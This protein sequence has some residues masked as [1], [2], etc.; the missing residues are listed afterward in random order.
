[1][2]DDVRL[3]ELMGFFRVKA[4]GHVLGDAVENVL[5]QGRRMRRGRNRMQVDDAKIAF[6]VFQHGRP[7]ATAPR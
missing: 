4:T 1:M 7:I 6:V 2:T 3:G 5:P